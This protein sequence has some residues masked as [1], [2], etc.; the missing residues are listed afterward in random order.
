MTEAHFWIIAASMLLTTKKMLQCLHRNSCGPEPG[1]VP[2][3]TL[4]IGSESENGRHTPELT[5]STERENEAGLV[6]DLIPANAEAAFSAFPP[7]A[8]IRSQPAARSRR[9]NI[10]R[11]TVTHR[12]RDQ[13]HGHPP[14][15]IGRS[16][17]DDKTVCVARPKKLVKDDVKTSGR[18]RPKGT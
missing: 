17:V 5:G 3:R 16:A 4:K 6:L 12:T 8:Q 14:D 15:G 18:L 10:V 1:E 7:S 2:S 9:R 11:A 13:R